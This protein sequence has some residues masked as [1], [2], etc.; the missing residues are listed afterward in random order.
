MSWEGDGLSVSVDPDSW[1][2][3][4]PVGDRAVALERRDGSPG[5]FLDGY[6]AQSDAIRWGKAVG[7]AQTV[8][9]WRASDGVYTSEASARGEH[10]RARLEQIEGSGPSPAFTLWLE[11]AYG[12]F[13]IGNIHPVFAGE[14]VNRYAG[15]LPDALDG[16]W[17][18]DRYRVGVSAPA[19]LILPER[20]AA[21]HVVAERRGLG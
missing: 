17:W 14:L 21:W 6:A 7:L 20:L 3:I 10:P 12:R 11:E 15:A 19:G 5:R 1:A 4:A 9:L 16:V 2:R 18:N 8:S 13:W